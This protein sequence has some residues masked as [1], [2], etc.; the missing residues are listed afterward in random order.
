MEKKIRIGAKL[1]S[2]NNEIARLRDALA[3]Y[4]SV[5]A[6]LAI[7][8]WSNC[9]ANRDRGRLAQDALSEK[10]TKEWC[11]K[12][13]KLEGDSEVGAGLLAADPVFD[14]DDPPEDKG[15]G[16]AAGREALDV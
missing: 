11:I 8:A 16:D 13:A 1:I 7:P 2:A 14:E 5:G 12:M 15:Q 6:W 9:P 4:G 10:F 3:W